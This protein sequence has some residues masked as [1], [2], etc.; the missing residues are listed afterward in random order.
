M[1][2]AREADDERCLLTANAAKAY[3]DGL[4][5]RLMAVCLVAVRKDPGG[6][7]S[8]SVRGDDTLTKFV[9][10]SPRRAKRT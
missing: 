6:A 5:V 1:T 3:A 10:S 2:Q 9:S 7:E 8:A 4:A